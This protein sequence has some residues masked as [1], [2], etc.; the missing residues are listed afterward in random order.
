MKIKENQLTKFFREL[1]EIGD[2][3]TSLGFSYEFYEDG[4]LKK[5]LLRMGIKSD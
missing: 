2:K 5:N 1:G 3:N 4:E